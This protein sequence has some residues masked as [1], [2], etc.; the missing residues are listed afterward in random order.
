MVEAVLKSGIGQTGFLVKIF[1]LGKE[2]DDSVLKG[3]E[4]VVSRE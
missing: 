3:H 4:E 2:G 1:I